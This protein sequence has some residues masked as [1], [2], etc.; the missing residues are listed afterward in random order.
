[1]WLSADGGV[2]F[3]IALASN[4][5]ASL[6]KVTVTIPTLSAPTTMARVRVQ[7]VAN[8]ATSGTS[9]ANFK[10]QPPYVTVTR[11]NTV[12]HLWTIGTTQKVAWTNNLG[13]LE[14]VKIEL[15][16]DGGATYTVVL[17]ASTPSDGSLLVAV[18]AAWATLHGRVRVSWVKN[19]AVFDVSNVDF[20]IQ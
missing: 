15:S 11:P 17:S 18:Q 7:W 6:K 20:V 3:P 4:V 13:A 8:P 2:T 5:T 19:G 16:L 1:V 10:V 9:P 14:D 12:K